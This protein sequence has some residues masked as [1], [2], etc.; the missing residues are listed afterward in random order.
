MSNHL[1]ILVTAQLRKGLLGGGRVSVTKRGKSSC[2]VAIIGF[3]FLLGA[4]GNASAV[5]YFNWGVETLLVNYGGTQGTFPVVFHPGNTTMDCTVFHSG[6][7]SMKL[8]VI[9]NDSGNQQMGVDLIQMNPDYPFNLVGG[10]AVYYRWWM[11]IMPG[12]SWGNGTAKTKASRVISGVQGY[13]G[14]L[15]D[16]GFLIGECDSGGC[17][18][19]NGLSNGGDSSLI[20]NYDFRSHADGVWHEYIVRIKPNTSATCTAP[21]NCDA[22]FQAWVDGFS[23][24]QYNGYKLHNIAGDGMTEAWGGWMVSP[25]FQLNAT[26]SDGGTIYLDDFSTDDSWNSLIPASPFGGGLAPPNNLRVQ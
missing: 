20:I 16:N 21:S 13:T 19:N 6:K 25:Y 2:L 5:N 15:M 18:L 23:V 4:S 7:F 14:Y 24:G 17:T 26:A 1:L 10:L 12:F 11:K 9:G 22:Q 8:S 3:L